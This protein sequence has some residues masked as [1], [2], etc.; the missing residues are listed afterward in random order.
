MLRLQTVKKKIAHPHD[1]IML[2]HQYILI[3]V[4]SIKSRHDLKFEVTRNKKNVYIGYIGK[5]K[6]KKRE[7]SKLGRKTNSTHKNNY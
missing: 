5:Q 2:L 4:I 3:G 7:K 1:G 6:K